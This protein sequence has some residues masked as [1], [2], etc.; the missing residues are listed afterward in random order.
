MSNITPIRADQSSNWPLISCHF[1]SKARAKKS[2]AEPSDSSP[3]KRQ[4]T[5]LI[6]GVEVVP[7]PIACAEDKMLLRNDGDMNDSPVA[8]DAQESLKCIMI[9]FSSKTTHNQSDDK[10][11]RDQEYSRDSDCPGSEVLSMECEGV[12]VWDVILLCVS[13]S[14]RGEYERAAY[15]NRAQACQHHE[16]FPKPASRLQCHLKWATYSIHVVRHLPGSASLRA[17]VE[18]CS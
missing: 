5:W 12:V 15:R 11:E 4:K 8:D 6:P 17:A 1:H 2:K 10:A 14:R 9:V 13:L 7:A 16:E 3:S 18:R